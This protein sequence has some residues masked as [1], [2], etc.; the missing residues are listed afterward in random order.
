MGDEMLDMV[1]QN[2]WCVLPYSVVKNLL[3]LKLVPT[4]VVPQQ[5]RHPQPIIDYSWCNIYQDSMP[6]A[7]IEAMQFGKTFSWLMQQLVDA[8]AEYAAPLMMKIDL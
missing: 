5:V 4:G 1:Q 6:V 2:Y 7:P 3:N 8:P